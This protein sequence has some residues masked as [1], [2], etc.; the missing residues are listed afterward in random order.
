MLL[1]AHNM[2]AREYLQSANDFIDHNYH[3]LTIVFFLNYLLTFTFWHIVIKMLKKCSNKSI[4]TVPPPYVHTVRFTYY[5]V[6]VFCV[7]SS[8]LCLKWQFFFLY[9]KYEGIFLQS[10]S[11]FAFLWFNNALHTSNVYY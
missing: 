9:K 11:H 1:C 6:S 3:K 4:T 10:D 5:T 7:L 8:N 2:V